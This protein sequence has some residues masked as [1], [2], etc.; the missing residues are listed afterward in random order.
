MTV[1]VVI[2]LLGTLPV[3]CEAPALRDVAPLKAFAQRSGT[4]S[5]GLDS[6]ATWCFDSA[7]TWTGGQRVEGKK[8]K[9]VDP[10]APPTGD[11]ARALAS[12]DDARASLTDELAKVLDDAL[13]DLARPYRGLR[14]VPRR[15]GLDERPSATVDCGERSRPGLF[16]QAQARMDLARLASVVQNEYAN[17]KTWL[18]ARG[19]ECA[20]QVRSEQAAATRVTVSVDAPVAALSPEPAGASKPSAPD[21]IAPAPVVEAARVDARG[22]NSSASATPAPGA[23]GAGA[24]GASGGSAVLAV[25]AGDAKGSS[26]KGASA[27]GP[28]AAGASGPAVASSSPGAGRRDDAK[29]S[30]AAGTLVAGAGGPTGASGLPVVGR[31]DAQGA[32]AP[33]AVGGAGP[34]AVGWSDVKASTGASGT[35]GGSGSRT[36]GRGDVAGAIGAGLSASGALVSGPGDAKDA[37]AAGAGPKGGLMSGGGAGPGSPA[38]LVV[39]APDARVSTTA[40]ALTPGASGVSQGDAKGPVGA[41]SGAPGALTA[42]AAT[43]APAGAAPSSTPLVA[44]SSG[45]P[46]PLPSTASVPGASGLGGA[47]AAA[48]AP[49]LLEVWRGLAQ[50]RGKMELDRDYLMGFLASRELRDCRC[51]RPSPAGIV[52]RLERDDGVAQLEAEHPRA[53][54]CELCVQ[55]AFAAWKSRAARQCALLFDLSPYELEVLQKSDD[56]NG[57]PPR[58]WEEVVSRRGLDAGVALAA[59]P[60]PPR[61]PAAADAGARPPPPVAASGVPKV[62]PASLGA[63]GFMRPSEP[64][65]I[66]L[67]EEGRFYVR[68]FMSSTCAADVLPGPILARTGDLLLIPFGARQLSLR[69]PCGG[70]AEVYWGREAAPRVSEVFGRNQPLH[71]QFKPQ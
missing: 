14:Y 35:A 45:A 39:G 29:G 65:P 17:Y 22:A 58:C 46:S 57:L 12:C 21:P 70:L 15:S 64:A 19:L 69:S 44:G 18:F 40:S 50:Q 33:G 3:E 51:Q 1:L 10:A 7:G 38:P 28:L 53:L 36:V 55:N 41:G 16:A 25:D 34:L 54:A 9:P 60:A 68:V 62:E 24:S 6:I 8:P 59:A 11:C 27:A 66:P 5:V 71:L 20:Q 56:G 4:L 37:T 13:A 42:G 43:T 52:A 67:R 47:P 31:G 63:D 23:G 61:P 49:T 30:T 26:G 48:P 32:S 2:S